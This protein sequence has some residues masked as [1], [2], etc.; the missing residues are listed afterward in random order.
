M[1]EKQLSVILPVYNEEKNIETVINDICFNLSLIMDKFEIIVVNDGS[2]DGTQ[3]IL[4]KISLESEHVNIIT[5]G[6]NSGYGIALMSGVRNAKYPSVFLMDADGQFNTAELEKAFGYLD[7]F[8]IVMGYRVRRAD[9]FYRTI[10]ARG[11]GCLVFLFFGLRFK[12][13]NCGFK[14][15]K[16]SVLS[17]KNKSIGGVFYTEVLLKA[18]KRGLR[19]KEIPVVHFPRLKGKQTGASPR[20]IFDA[21]RDLVKLKL[22]LIRDKIKIS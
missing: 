18:K 9:S 4:S 20:V 21:L 2:T 14:L 6:K 19:I 12:D 3:G 15:F 5:H 22:A 11:Y 17:E 1:T 13:V 7:E 16:K 10:F 8:D